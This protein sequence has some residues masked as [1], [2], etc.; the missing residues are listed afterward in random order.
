MV[1]QACHASTGKRMEEDQT[2]EASL[3]LAWAKW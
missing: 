3:R 2:L 1:A